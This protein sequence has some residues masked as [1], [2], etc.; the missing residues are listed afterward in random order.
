MQ[1][2][3]K[4]VQNKTSL[5]YVSPFIPFALNVKFAKR[6]YSKDLQKYRGLL[7]SRLYPVI[8]EKCWCDHKSSW[9][10]ERKFSTKQVD[11]VSLEV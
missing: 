4:N 9:C 5:F 2:Y 6:S 1:F 8:E 7:L 3:R 10:L 11:G